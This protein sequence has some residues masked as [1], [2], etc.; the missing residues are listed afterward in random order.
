MA[1]QVRYTALLLLM[2]A[3]LLNSSHRMQTEHL[4]MSGALHVSAMI[5]ALTALVFV[6]ALLILV[7][8]Y[9][10]V[11]AG[12]SALIAAIVFSVSG[13]WALRAQGG[14]SKSSRALTCVA[15]VSTC[16]MIA[17]AVAPQVWLPALTVLAVCLVV[18]LVA[19]RA[20]FFRIM[21]SLR[22]S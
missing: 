6:V 1:G 20:L 13:A 16:A 21:R 11:G 2:G 4:A 19:E 15:F 10:A 3:Q 14:P 7:P 9:S 17:G 12:F 22:R 18:I 5:N 8:G